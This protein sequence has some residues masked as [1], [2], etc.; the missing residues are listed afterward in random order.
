MANPKPT[1]S[2][3]QDASTISPELVR[4]V[5]EAVYR[6]LQRDLRIEHERQRRARG[7]NRIYQR[8]R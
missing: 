6:L 5:A 3:D 4:E 8:G 1:Q 2:A 7:Q